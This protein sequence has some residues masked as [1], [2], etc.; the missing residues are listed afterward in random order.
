MRSHFED[1]RDALGLCVF[2]AGLALGATPKEL[3]MNRHIASTSWV[4]DRLTAVP[5]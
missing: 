2:L 1:G 5:A 4:E 3:G